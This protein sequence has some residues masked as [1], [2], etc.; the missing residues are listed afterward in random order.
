MTSDVLSGRID[1][2]ARSEI[3]RALGVSGGC[4]GRDCRKRRFPGGQK[5]P[6]SVREKIANPGDTIG[7]FSL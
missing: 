3:R 4:Q 7:L 2:I 5:E 1:T 6:V